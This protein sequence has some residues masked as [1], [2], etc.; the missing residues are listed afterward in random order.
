MLRQDYAPLEVI[1][2]DNCSTDGTW[3][4]VCTLQDQ[5]LVRTR[6]ECNVGMFGNFNRCL[7]SATG[8]YIRFLCSDDQLT[9]GTIEKEVS[10]LR[11]NPGVSLLSTRS[12]HINDSGQETCL[13][14]MHAP[15][16]VH[17]G[18]DAVWMAAWALSECGANLFCFPSGIMIRRE[19]AL[20]AG[21]FDATLHGLADV[22]YWWRVLEHGDACFADHAGCIVGE[23][24]SR[25]SFDL[26]W[27]GLYMRGHFEVVGRLASKFPAEG[28]HSARALQR[29]MGGR[30]LWYVLKS[31]ASAKWPS[32]RVHRALLREYGVPVHHA[33]L[34][35]LR[36]TAR[37]ARRRLSLG[38]DP[39]RREVLAALADREA[40]SGVAVAGFA[41]RAET[42]DKLPRLAG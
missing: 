3:E 2:V 41:E 34:G 28:R 31:I 27:R 36:E 40:R 35:L 17:R 32:A 18:D 29:R 4:A 1:V 20:R 22:D 39:L 7:E 5:R 33:L 42:V 38:E 14:G 37:R 24:A 12:L 23:H 9:E 11:T 19:S 13:S 16:G 8:E 26:F 10:L 30:C 21:W 6:N 15:P 25:A